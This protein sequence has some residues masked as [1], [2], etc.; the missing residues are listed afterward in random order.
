MK[1]GA[2]CLMGL[3]I[4]TPLVASEPVPLK[5]RFD[6]AAVQWVTQPGDSQVTGTAFL[7]LADGTRKS[8]A[9]FKVELLPVADY[10][11]ERIGLTY[12]NNRSG[13]IL[14]EQNPPAFTPDDPAYHELL[15]ES[16]CDAHGSFVFERVPAG[17]YYVMVFVI[18]NDAVGDG[19]Q[20]QG[21]AVMERIRVPSG[22]RMNIAMGH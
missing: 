9:G 13:Q 18:W 17:E 15:L 10:S 12:G 19:N 11:N 8:C 14:L 4:A 7:V 6:P 3:F 16:Q 21:G 5:S 22:A 2:T 20:R 1:T